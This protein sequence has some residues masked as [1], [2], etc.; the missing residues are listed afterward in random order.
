[1]TGSVTVS[2]NASN[3]PDIITF[4]GTGVALVNHSVSLSWT[5]ST[6]ANVTSYNNY[7]STRS[8][9]PYTRLTATPS[10]TTT[11]TDTTVQTGQTY[12]YVV[13]SVDSNNVES[14]YSTEVSA[15]VP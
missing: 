10:S 7:S 3:S 14:A 11:Y 2:S 1:L 12:Y 6:S 8:G 5:A 9:G 15:I 4:T 13:T